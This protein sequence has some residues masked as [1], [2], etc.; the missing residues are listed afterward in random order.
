MKSNS[1]S[2]GILTF[3]RAYNSGAVLQAYALKK[4]INTEI[5]NAEIIDFIPNNAC[6]ERNWIVQWILHTGKVLI[7]LPFTKEESIREYRFKAFRK[8]LNLSNRTYFGDADI[9]RNPPSYDVLISGSDQIFN[10]TLSDYSKSYYLGF[11]SSAKK[12]SYGSSFGRDILTNAEYELIRQE[13]PQFYALSAREY[14]GANIMMKEI[15]KSVKIVVDPVFLISKKEWSMIKSKKVK[16]QRRYIFVYAMEKTEW[17]LAALNAVQNKFPDWDTVC[18][19]AGWRA[20]KNIPGLLHQS[21]GPTE[22]L[23]YIENAEIVVTNSF[24]GTAFSLIFEKKFVCIAHS[25]YNARLENILELIGKREM[26]LD[27]IIDKSWIERYIIDGVNSFKK[28]NGLIDES[29][30]YLEGAIKGNL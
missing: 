27:K 1:I 19:C 22:F 8:K 26:L 29:K 25:K 20:G 6:P 11:D 15:G 24:H 4:Y 5:G 23:A 18:V 13:L 28:M 16:K 30:A 14:S 9:F 10:M 3:H 7:T 2:I 12:I 17:L 21:C